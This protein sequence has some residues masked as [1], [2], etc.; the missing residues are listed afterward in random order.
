MK[1]ALG[2]VLGLPDKQTDERIKFFFDQFTALEGSDDCYYILPQSLPAREDL[3]KWASF[4]NRD[5]HDVFSTDVEA[6]LDGLLVA[7]RDHS[8][9]LPQVSKLK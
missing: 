7:Y 1:D 2:I 5:N 6:A 4:G 3:I 8:P 9:S